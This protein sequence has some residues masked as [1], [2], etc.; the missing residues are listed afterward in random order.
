[1]P[2]PTISEYIDAI[3]C[4]EDNFNE[5]RNLRPVLDAKGDLVMSSGNFAVVFKMT[6]GEKDYA[7]K[8]FT[9]DQEGRDEA[10]KLIEKELDG[11]DSS[12]I[13]KLR[14]LEKELYVDT[15]QTDETEFPVLMMDWVEGKPLDVFIQENIND[16]HFKVALPYNFSNLA[17]WL[18][19]QPFAH[20]DLKP[21]NI[22][23]DFDGSLTLVDYDGVFVPAMDGQPARELGTP[24]Y[25]H[26]ARTI[27]EFDE[28]IDDYALS[29][30]LLYVK[31]AFLNPRYQ[32]ID[33]FFAL[34]KN[35]VLQPNLSHPVAADFSQLMQNADF[36][37]LYGLFLNVYNHRSLRGFPVKCFKVRGFKKSCDVQDLKSKASLGDGQVCYELG[38]Y[39]EDETDYD[40]SLKWH[41]R[42]VQLG[43]PTAICGVCRSLS[44]N[45]QKS[46]KEKFDAFVE[47]AKYGSLMATCRLGEY[48]KDGC[49]C[50]EKDERKAIAY[51]QRAAQQ[52]FAPAQDS[53]GRCY[54]NGKGV[55]KNEAKAVEWYKKSAEQ[56]Y[57][58]AQYD[59]GLCYTRGEG[60]TKDE[61][62]AAE[63]YRKAAKQGFAAAQ[64]ILGEYYS[65]GPDDTLNYDLSNQWLRK[66]VEQ[67]YAQAQYT[68]GWRYEQGLVVSKD[69]PLAVEWYRK[70][71][72]QG[73][74]VAQCNLGVCYEYGKGVAKDEAIA[75]KWYKKAA[76]QGNARAQF[77]LG[78][79]YAHGKGV[80][81]DD[82]A[83]V[84]W[85]KKAAEQGHI[86]AQFNLGVCYANGTGIGKDNEAAVE[87]YK[88]AA[89]QGYIIAQFNLGVCYANGIGI[90]KD[91]SIAVHWYRKAAEQG[92]AGAQC[93]LGF[94][95]AYG[96]GVCKDEDAAVEWYKKAAEQ[97]HII[98][99]FNLGV[100]YEYGNGIP[101]DLDLAIDWYGKAA[102]QGHSEAKAALDRLNLYPGEY[103]F[104]KNHHADDVSFADDLPF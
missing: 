25:R 12:Y 76:E 80:C 47:A 101:K 49:D 89:E 53:L 37:K 59:L 87:W 22:L 65:I 38:L 100:C 78:F 41:K 79:C 8:C 74:A 64:S 35:I 6:D 57:A 63:W 36:V 42:A 45:P 3:R 70:A 56:G 28:H 23:V 55:A 97:G 60:V 2:Y 103:L 83:A 27:N 40:E 90:G 62:I 29:L 21:D 48:H 85:Y 96:K 67:G 39:Y 93:N 66:A 77:K 95:Y 102:I 9:R 20:G 11:V 88:K 92:Y 104:S 86:I 72:E 84:E 75:V 99:Q 71:A 24:E 26:P 19:Q 34:L 10:Y 4:A 98:A 73:H 52:G 94:C 7:I 51:Y 44:R 13:V 91:E 69:L 43:H 30:L 54:K 32:T 68:L 61:T 16:E 18:F 33:S 31:T 5:L 17:Q 50:V 82:E 58:L 46:S 14:Y 15:R 81:K 1:M